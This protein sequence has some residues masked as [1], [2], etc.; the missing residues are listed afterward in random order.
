MKI[1]LAKKQDFKSILPLFQNLDIKHSKNSNDVRE[2]IPVERYKRI[3]QNIFKEKTNYV[4]TV[5]EDNNI[6]IAFALGKII[7]IKNSLVY[8][9]NSIGEVLYVIV[10]DEYKMNGIGLVNVREIN[11]T[12]EYTLDYIEDSIKSNLGGV[13][14]YN[15]VISEGGYISSAI[16]IQSTA[17]ASDSRGIYFASDPYGGGTNDGS[18]IKDNLSALNERG[19][20]WQ[21]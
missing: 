16:G 14:A 21:M 5:T 4:L 15:R 7:T 10:K 8:K 9:N 17:T 11:S 3:F 19:I 1:R 20:K 18:F 12:T 13:K 6:I 2:K